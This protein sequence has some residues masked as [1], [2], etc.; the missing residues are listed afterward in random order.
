LQSKKVLLA[1]LVWKVRTMCSENIRTSIV[2]RSFASWKNKRLTWPESCNLTPLASSAILDRL[3]LKSAP[4][5]KDAWR[6][7]S[8]NGRQPGCPSD[9]ISIPTSQGWLLWFV[10]RTDSR[11]SRADELL[12][13]GAVHHLNKS[14][15]VTVQSVLPSFIGDSYVDLKREAGC[16]SSAAPQQLSDLG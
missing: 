2:Y 16:L 4:C 15:S 10:K 1:H 3:I 11:W 13:A 9:N 7:T 14:Y 12:G 5:T 6:G 8:S